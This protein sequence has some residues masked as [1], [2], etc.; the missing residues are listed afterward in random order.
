MSTVHRVPAAVL[1]A[2]TAVGLPVLGVPAAA[3]DDGPPSEPSELAELQDQATEDGA[4]AVLVAVQDGVA[5]PAAAVAAELAGTDA[6]VRLVS[7][8]IVAVD[9]DPAALDRLASAEVVDDVGADPVLRLATTNPA[10]ELTRTGPGHRLGHTGSGRMVAV[11]DTGVDRSHPALAAAVEAE[12]CFVAGL[13]GRCPNGQP[14]QVGDGA[15]APCTIAPSACGHGTHVAGIAV[16]RAVGSLGAG[17]AP[18]AGLV[19]IRI[20]DADP[21]VPGQVAAR[22]S[23]LIA[24]LSHVRQLRST[25]P[26]D[27][28]NLSISGSASYDRPCDGPE[29]TNVSVRALAQAVDELRAAGVAT[30]AATGNGSNAERISFPACVSAVIR[31]A[32]S[33]NADTVATFANRNPWVTLVAP[34]TDVIA[35]VPG[36]RAEA[37]SGTSMAAP[38]VTGAIALL[39]QR[40]RPP[41]VGWIA[42]RMEATGQPIVDTG[43]GR[44]LR[45]LDVAAALGLAPAASGQP[46]PA[47]GAWVVTNTGRA[48]P[49]GAARDLG[50]RAPLAS[51]ERVVAAS[52]SRSGLGLWMASDRGRVTG[53]GDARVF[54]DASALPLQRPIT[55][56][57]TTATG[58]GYWLLGADGGIFTYG[59]ALFHG[60]TGDLRLNAP[61][62]DL[63]ASP[64]N[65]GYWLTAR[66][67]GVFSFGDARFHGSTGGLVL[68]Q[69]VVS[70]AAG[71]AS[72]YWLVALDG[73]VFAFDVPFLGSLP[74][75]GVPVTNSLRIRASAAG[76]GYHVLTAD[77]VVRP[78]GRADPFRPATLAPGEHAVDLVVLP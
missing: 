21:A 66:D 73:G 58:G 2:L 64:T 13:D 9:A 74:S 6:E 32:A 16:G 69:P 35:A 39:H 44:T 51:G 50:G 25:L 34:G 63:A 53:F 11:I 29:V 31:V 41:D 22:T 28:V 38:Q 52:A 49:V 42:T 65:G 55:A 46:V 54:G 17:V 71:P 62:T 57:A 48:L 40:Y 67:G 23:D 37:R 14:T 10:A 30:V 70:V 61:V 7:E 76:T 15:G 77:G 20:F 78:F 3:S 5:D 75:I 27:A 68:Q 26:I 8:G 1:L 19:S 43:S 72:G 33:T 12:A 56:M 18:A 4:V 24:A 36:D 45:R 47:A 60:S 59:D